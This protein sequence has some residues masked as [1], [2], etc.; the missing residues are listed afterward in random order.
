MYERESNHI[1]N[2]VRALH[3]K[4]ENG[5]VMYIDWA[6]EKRDVY[7]VCVLSEYFD[8]RENLMKEVK[9]VLDAEFHNK[10]HRMFQVMSDTEMEL[11]Y[12]HVRGR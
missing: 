1:S 3:V 2:M 5:V 6:E 4:Y 7:N 11:V 10:Q 12:G 9:S 8:K